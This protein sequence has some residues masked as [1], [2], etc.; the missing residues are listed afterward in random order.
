MDTRYTYIPCRY[1]VHFHPMR[2]PGKLPPPVHTRY[3]SILC[4]YQV[5]FHPM[6]IPGTL[7]SHVDTRY[8]SIPCG[9]QVHFH[10]MRILVTFQIHVDDWYNSAYNRSMVHPQASLDVFRKLLLIR[11]CCPDR[12]LAQVSLETE[13]CPR[14]DKANHFSIRLGST[15]TVPLVPT[16]WRMQFLISSTCLRKVTTRCLKTMSK[17][18]NLYF[19]LWH[20]LVRQ[21]PCDI[22]RD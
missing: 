22:T 6:W 14:H 2:I 20:R 15:S 13:W 9:Y 5:N 3:T 11:S 10:P 16:S 17:S 18:A 7:S 21:R 4:G 8:T 1:Q 19:Q 12:T